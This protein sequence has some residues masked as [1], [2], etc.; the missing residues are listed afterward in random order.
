MHPIGSLLGA[1][2]TVT[3]GSLPFSKRLANLGLDGAVIE[4]L[5]PGI[6]P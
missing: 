2:L 5:V 4:G 6:R 1:V 3:A